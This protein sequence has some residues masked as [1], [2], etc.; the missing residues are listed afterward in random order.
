MSEYHPLTELMNAMTTRLDTIRPDDVKDIPEERHWKLI[1][2]YIAVDDVLASLYKQYCEAKDNLGKLL[3]SNGSDDPL[4]EIAWDMHDSLRS[5]IE[6]RLLELR[7]DKDATDRALA[8]QSRQFER[9]MIKRSRK[10]VTQRLDETMAFM[11][12]AGMA[13]KNGLPSQ[14]MRRDFGRVS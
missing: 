13:M 2:L 6:T 12:L 3:V 4:S 11:L 7:E 1:T 5:S 10:P 14:D 9:K 8:L